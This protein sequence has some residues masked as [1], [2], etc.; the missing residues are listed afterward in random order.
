MLIKS[1][2]QE[3]SHEKKPNRSIFFLGDSFGKP[4]FI[5]HVVVSKKEDM[6]IMHNHFKVAADFI[7]KHSTIYIFNRAQNTANVN[8]LKELAHKYKDYKFE[9]LNI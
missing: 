8:L 4:L 1:I 9:N 6:K 3:L 5:G 2:S 7:E